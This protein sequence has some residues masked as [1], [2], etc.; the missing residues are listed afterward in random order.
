MKSKY[1]VVVVF[2]SCSTK[3]RK[4]FRESAKARNAKLFFVD[5][6]KCRGGGIRYTSIDD[7][8]PIVDLFVDG[9]TSKG[10]PN[11]SKLAGTEVVRGTCCEEVR[12]ERDRAYDEFQS[13]LTAFAFTVSN[14]AYDG[15][16]A[17]RNMIA[18]APIMLTRLTLCQLSASFDCPA[19]AVGSGPSLALHLDEIRNLQ[20]KFLIFCAESA[21][22][23]LLEAGIRPNFVC[24][25]ERVE[26]PFLT[27]FREWAPAEWEPWCICTPMIHPYSLDGF[28][29]R[30]VPVASWNQPWQWYWS[31]HAQ[32][33]RPLIEGSSTGVCA[34]TYAASL[35]TGP[36]Y[37]VGNDCAYHDNDSHWSGAQMTAGLW[38]RDSFNESRVCGY[39]T[40]WIEK[41]GGGQV[42]SCRLW[43]RFRGEIGARALAMRKRNRLVINTN[44]DRGATIPYAVT[45]PLPTKEQAKRFPPFKLKKQHQ[46]E[47]DGGPV[48]E[49]V[50]MVMHMRE[51]CGAWPYNSQT[52]NQ[53]AINMVTGCIDSCGNYWKYWNDAEGIKC[54]IGP[55]MREMKT[56]AI[57]RIYPELEGILDSIESQP[58]K[59]IE[60]LS[61]REEK[62]D[63]P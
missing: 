14:S 33:R 5:F 54:D 3:E 37:L 52:G 2:G 21:I 49:W 28:R 40:V 44:I 20:G 39:D 30:I 27:K 29:G 23:G 12:E 42:R 4:A 22:H 9:I 24:P 8:Q 19:I 62:P 50:E 25:Q 53:D 15:W 51:E 46:F 59:Y 10:R 41:N 45:S 26:S 11:G 56:A 57:Q 60:S 31:K 58:K 13:C 34:V 38:E 6:C 43:A 36:I 7:L 17:V 1:Q 35:T 47:P 32:P 63:G 61:A 18:N 55:S 48:T 16:M